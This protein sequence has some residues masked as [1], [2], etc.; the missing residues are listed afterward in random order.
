LICLLPHV[1]GGSG[2]AAVIDLLIEYAHEYCSY[3]H[4]FEFTSR[5]I[6][7][8]TMTGVGV[9]IL[10]GETTHSAAYLNQK[11]PIEAEQIELWRSTRLLIIDEIPFPSKEDFME[12]HKKLRQ[13]KQ[14]LH[15]P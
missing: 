1:P 5:T 10:M 14:C 3:L 8:T 15:L 11:R 7:V 6:V 4:N 12:L 13:L 2:K 9:T